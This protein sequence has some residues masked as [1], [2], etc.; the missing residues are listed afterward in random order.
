M[1]GT[2]FASQFSSDIENYIADQ[3]LP[4]ARRQLCAYRFGDPLELDKGRGVTYTATRFNRL[5]LPFQPISEGVPPTQG[6]SMTLTQITAT[7]QQWGDLV[8][9]TDVAEMTIK[10][11]LVAKANELMALQMSETLE[12]NTFNSLNALTQVN[13]VNSR[14]SRAA[15]LAND[16][17]DSTTINRTSALMINLGAPRFMGDEQTDT[18]K[19][20]DQGGGRASNS[21]RSM[22]HYAAIVHPFVAADFSN[23][24]DVKTAWQYSDINRLYNFETGEWRGIRFCESNMVPTWTGVATLGG[25]AAT[26][27][28]LA[29]GNYFVQVTASDTQNQYESRVYQV[30]GS[31]AVTGPNG[32]VTV[33]LPSL[34]GFTFN[35][36]IGTTSSPQ[37][38]GLC[39]LGP[40]YGPLSGQATQLAGGQTVTITGTGV[41]QV[42]PAAPAT[43]VTVYPTYVF[44][45]GAYG[46]VK[47]DNA[48][49]ALLKDADKSDPMNQIRVLSWKLMYSTIILNVAFATRIESTS[50]IF[51]FG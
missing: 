31:I 37:N 42:P 22:P 3:V 39:A 6:E 18:D 10:H 49:F 21:P 36:Y 9:I 38:L 1:Q 33:T 27:G 13:Y 28:S 41:A 44:G 48:K 7:C 16:N 8:K 29:T 24:S 17:L 43:G 35:V 51:A 46:Q 20:V 5:P 50:S 12:R 14:G 11:P 23:A 2:N 15:L 4:L 26:T 30:S 34:P 45:R 47:L 32:S 40:A 19:D 25:T